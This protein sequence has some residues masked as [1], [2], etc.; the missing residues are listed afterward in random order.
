MPPS[1]P[2]EINVI[3]F[4]DNNRMDS[5]LGRTIYKKDSSVQSSSLGVQPKIEQVEV[6]KAAPEV[7]K[8]KVIYE[9][10]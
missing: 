10:E 3:S 2:P 8:S 5:F 7:L 1:V 6:A 9:A 4:V